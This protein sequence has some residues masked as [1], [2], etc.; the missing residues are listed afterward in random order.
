MFQYRK[1]FIDKQ[2]NRLSIGIFTLFL[3][4]YATSLSGSVIEY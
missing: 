4:L 3:L 2:F 1:Q